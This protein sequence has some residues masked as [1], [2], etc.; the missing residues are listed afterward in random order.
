MFRRILLRP[1]LWTFLISLITYWD[2]QALH[3]G[4]V[5]DDSASLKH[6]PLVKAEVPWI[7]ILS[8]DFWGTP[9][10]EAASH[11]SFRP[12][13]TLSFRWNWSVS[14]ANGTDR[15]ENQHLYGF[16]I[17]NVLLHALVTA[18]ATEASG[19]VL[20]LDRSKDRNTVAQF[21]TGVLFAIH[22]VHCETVSNV[23][24][25]G[26][27]LMS[28]FSML[29]FLSFANSIPKP[30]QKQQPGRIRVFFFVYSVPWICMTLSLFSKEQGATTLITLVV[31]DFVRHHY[32]VR[33]YL[34]Q[35]FRREKQA[36]GFLCRTVILAVQTL[37]VL[38][39]R[40]WLNGNTHPDFVEE[41][42][43]AGFAKD[44]FTRAFSVSWVYCLYIYDAVYPWQL[45]PDWSG[46][47]IDLIEG[48]SDPRAWCVMLLWLCTVGFVISLFW[49]L[50]S[51]ASEDSRNTRK[52][53]VSAFFAFLFAPF[54]LSSNILVTV[55]LMK[56]DRVIYAP[57]LGVCMIGGLFVSRWCVS[58]YKSTSKT[59][60]TVSTTTPSRSPAAGRTLS[61]LIVMAQLFLFT[62]KTHERNVAW[63]SQVRLWT[64]AYLLNPRS[65]HTQYN[66]GF[67]LYRAKRYSEAE[68]ILRPIADP[69]GESQGPMNSYVYAMVLY[70]LERCPEALDVIAEALYAAD[71]LAKA[72]DLRHNENWAKRT[73]S[74]LLIAKAYCHQQDFLKYGQLVFEAYNTDPSNQYVINHMQ[75]LMQ[76]REMMQKRQEMMQ[77]Q[78]GRGG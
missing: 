66:C 29:A 16:H 64:S 13:T 70:Y 68:Q 43:P 67:H 21:V 58:Q 5:Y 14:V 10:R 47:S 22:P 32:S 45:G 75:D 46:N 20:D 57:L 11:K 36:V 38:A 44:R 39:F 60:E 31:W 33:N 73:K 17:V 27:L 74:G 76:K 69:W 51:K 24:S 9:L 59:T 40:M 19:W 65:L 63:S 25:R 62:G 53:M 55:G 48:I 49:G 35:L 15:D 18:L 56:A 28:F 6:N 12:L 3:G 71:E 61:Y 52:V 54:L 7:E 23:T 41:Q 50:P 37:L 30:G 26:E 77:R 42:N 1:S 72:N 8:R 2:D 34:P 78:Q 4:F